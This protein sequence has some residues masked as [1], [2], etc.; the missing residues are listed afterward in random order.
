MLGQTL[1]G[2]IPRDGLNSGNKKIQILIGFLHVVPDPC[3][4]KYNDLRIDKGSPGGALYLG[5][6]IYNYG[7]SNG[8]SYME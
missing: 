1:C 7:N 3:I 2:Q 4:L 8:T 6:C 5:T